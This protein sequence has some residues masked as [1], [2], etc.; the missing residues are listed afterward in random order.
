MYLAFYYFLSIVRSI[1]TPVYSANDEYFESLGWY[2][3]CI[4]SLFLYLLPLSSPLTLQ[5]TYRLQ[6]YM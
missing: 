6:Q 2:V 4:A 5:Y 3:F 1:I